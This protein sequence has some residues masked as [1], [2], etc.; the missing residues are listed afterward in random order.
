MRIRCVAMLA[1]GTFAAPA[2]AQ[3]PPLLGY[4]GRL[5]RAD[6]TA[7]TGMASVTFTVHDAASGGSM[8]WT[9]T[10]TLGLSDGYYSTFLGLVM[11][12]DDGDFDGGA[13][14]LQVQVG[15]ETLLPRQQIGSVAFA[16]QSASVRGTA[17]V[18]SLKVAGQT[19]IDS[20]GRLQ[21]AARYTGGAGI[22]VD[23]SQVVSLQACAAGQSLVRDATGWTCAAPGAIVDVHAAAPLS[24]SVSSA[25]AQL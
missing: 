4:Q 22:A 17:D 6:G 24:A 20:A 21:G 2:L 8:L 1:V 11:P 13:R 14:W 18:S 9:E 12:P 7:A 10:Q 15:G 19:V 25:T 3:V 16:L 5:L 23:A